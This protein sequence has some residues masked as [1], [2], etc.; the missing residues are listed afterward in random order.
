VVPAVAGADGRG[1]R[2]APP[3]PRGAAPARPSGRRASSTASWPTRSPSGAS[4]E[5]LVGGLARA[6]LVRLSPDTFEKDGRTI[7]F[8]RAALTPEGRSA[9]RAEL[10]A[11][12]LEVAADRPSPAKGPAKLPLRKPR[13]RTAGARDGRAAAVE[14]GPGAP[15]ALVGRLRAWRLEE[16]RRRRVPAFR[17]FGDRALLALAEARPSTEAGLLAV[18]GLGPK[19]V[20]RH[21]AALLKLLA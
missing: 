13:R 18:P 6:G 7:A 9:G 3:R 14:D 11:V 16:A 15:P 20:E 21:G 10:A 17:I 5:R 4:F 2:A 19:L 1:G 12:P 8:Q